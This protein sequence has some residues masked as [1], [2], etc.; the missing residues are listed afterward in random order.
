MPRGSTLRGAAWVETRETAC[1][2]AREG[3]KVVPGTHYLNSNYGGGFTTADASWIIGVFAAR[4]SG[5]LVDIGA[6]H[7]L[8]KGPVTVY[9]VST[10]AALI[11][12]PT[13]GLVYTNYTSPLQLG[14]LAPFS[15]ASVDEVLLT[16]RQEL[17]Q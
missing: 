15:P 17:C 1:A 16:A 4:S 13:G 2:E 12:G 14:S 7:P 9:G 10:G 5:G 6:G 3:E 8:P 11:A